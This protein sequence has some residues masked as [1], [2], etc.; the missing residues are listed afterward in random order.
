MQYSYPEPIVD[1]RQM[2]LEVI[3]FLHML[4]L[5]RKNLRLES[6][7]LRFLDILMIH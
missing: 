4:N 6:D 2:S 5:F 1:T 3:C 7:I